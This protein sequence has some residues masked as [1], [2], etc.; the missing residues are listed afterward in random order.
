MGNIDDSASASVDD[1]EKECLE[2]GTGY[3][4]DKSTLNCDYYERLNESIEDEEI[5]NCE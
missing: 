2:L 4:F 5:I 3:L 1:M